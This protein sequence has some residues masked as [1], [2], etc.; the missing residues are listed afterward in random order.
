MRTVSTPSHRET[1]LEAPDNQWIG[2]IFEEYETIDSTQR[3]AIEHLR[4]GTYGAVVSAQH[5]SAGVGRMGKTFWSPDSMGSYLSITLPNPN[6]IDRFPLLSLWAGVTV[7]RAIR[8][9][10]VVLSP[11][12]IN[13]TNRLTLKWPNDV[14]LD[15]KKIAGILVNSVINGSKPIGAVLGIGIN[16]NVEKKDFPSEIRNTATSIKIATANEWDRL[17]FQ[18]HLIAVI[19]RM[20][21]QISEPNDTVLSEW[22]RWGPVIGQAIAIRDNNEMFEGK[23]AGL[24]HEGELVLLM[25][26]GN[27]LSFIT[28]LIEDYSV[29]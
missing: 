20:W 26:D 12:P 21:H 18:Q 5:Q 11:I 6:P 23:F 27:K 16:L 9:A 2:S 17:Q 7:I 22:L 24:T 25:P 29:Q 28:G 3:R 10:G 1:L 15:G 19:E 8:E 4:N 13:L 14:L